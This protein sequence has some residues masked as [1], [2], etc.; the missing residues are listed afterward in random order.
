MTRGL[1]F[2]Q[3]NQIDPQ[4]QLDMFHVMFREI[5]IN[6]RAHTQAF[7][8]PQKITSFTHAALSK[9]LILLWLNKKGI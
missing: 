3:Q 2:S 9:Q 5:L 7:Q 8:S 6:K 1:E 4:A